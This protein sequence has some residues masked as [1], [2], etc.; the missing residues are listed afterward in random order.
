MT[1]L[2]MLAEQLAHGRTTIEEA[3][4]RARE[5]TSG[6]MRNVN[7]VPTRVLCSTQELHEEFR[8]LSTYLDELTYD[9]LERWA[10]AFVMLHAQL[11]LGDLR[12][13]ADLA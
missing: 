9:K 8:A 1:E 10:G 2:K 5:V 6:Q 13:A 4:R 12:A 7:W 3:G 11:G